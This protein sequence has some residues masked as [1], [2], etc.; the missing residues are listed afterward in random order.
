MSSHLAGAA[1][2]APPPGPG[3]PPAREVPA[4]DPDLADLTIIAR[5]AGDKLYFADVARLAGVAEVSIARYHTVSQASRNRAAAGQ[6]GRPP[7]PRDMPPPDGLDYPPGRTS[8][9]RS[10]WWSPATIA[11]WLAVRQG[12]GHP[13]ADGAKPAPAG[14]RLGRPPRK[15]GPK[16][17]RHRKT[18]STS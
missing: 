9:S 2:G 14:S 6:P 10:P 16:K 17:G 11:P 13:R 18:R 7:G 1:W 15:P 8:G 4:P 12:P 3:Q 5:R